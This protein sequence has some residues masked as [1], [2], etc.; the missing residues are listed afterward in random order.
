MGSFKKFIWS[1]MT[2]IL[3]IFGGSLLA[4]ALV[5][6]QAREDALQRITEIDYLL[7]ALICGIILLVI[8]LILLIDIITHNKNDREY[9]VESNSGDI[10]ITRN[11]LEALVETSVNQFSQ[12]RLDD[13]DVVIVNGE[14][15]EVDMIC[16]VFGDKDYDELGE[17]I[18]EEVKKGLRSLTGLE[19]VTVDLEL[20][21]A[22][23]YHARELV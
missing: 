16:D 19:E 21:K 12:A 14:K 23:S 11:S 20:N 5:D 2:I 1:L 10:F 3:I 9:L 8:A 13:V 15:I 22:E 6:D 4:I 7:A 17:M 18:Q